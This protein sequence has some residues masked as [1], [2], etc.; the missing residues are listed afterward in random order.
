MEQEA[1]RA[2]W[3]ADVRSDCETLYLQRVVYYFSLYIKV[4][5]AN[6]NKNLTK[7]K[8]LPPIGKIVKVSKRI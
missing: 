8:Y 3:A 5:S 6:R 7:E 2:S 4:F 1:L